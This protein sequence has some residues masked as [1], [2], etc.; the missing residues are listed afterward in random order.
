MRL[1]SGYRAD[2]EAACTP[3]VA[4]SQIM[5]KKHHLLTA[6]L[7]LLLSTAAYAQCADPETPSPASAAPMI[8]DARA[9][10][11]KPAA[12]PPPEQI[13]TPEQLQAGVKTMRDRGFLWRIRKDG[14]T[15]HLY[16]TIHIGRLEWAFLGKT[17]LDALRD[18]DVLALELDLSD[19]QIKA[20]ITRSAGAATPDF[21]LPAAVRE[22][23]DRQFAAACLPSESLA[24]LHPVMQAVTLTLLASRWDGLYAGFG[25]EF[26]LAGAARTLQ[27]QVVS[28][29][30]LAAQMQALVPNDRRRALALLERMLD[31]LE[32]DRVRPRFLRMSAAWERGDLTE[33][34][35]YEQWCDCVRDEDDRLLMK[36]LNDDRNQKLADGI[37]ALHRQG[38]KVF[39]AI[40]ALHMTGP[41]AL[42]RL[43]AERGFVVERVSYPKR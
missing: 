4:E 31:E 22:R 33:L 8:A 2:P 16:G 24:T 1:H 7:A 12:C 15:S 14:R 37:D 17:V 32:S 39:A 38:K 29:E 9:V 34:E 25:Q 27:R 5:N 23:L 35:S 43:L 3:S 36:R 20:S 11:S 40:G 6:F 13:P 21:T 19:P 30:T 42:P 41:Q 10:A 18:A 26:A 28:L